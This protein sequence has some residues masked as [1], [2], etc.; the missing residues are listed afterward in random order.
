MHKEVT[1]SKA[2]NIPNN[3]RSIVFVMETNGVVE[4]LDET[5]LKIMDK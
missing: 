4:K 2:G 5:A 3:N 1:H